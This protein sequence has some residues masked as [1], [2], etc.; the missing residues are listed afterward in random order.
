MA[1]EEDVHYVLEV[2]VQQVTKTS[3]H[4]PGTLGSKEVVERTVTELA[5]HVISE[6][7]MDALLK[8]GVKVIELVGE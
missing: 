8:K 2:K 4:V 3:S 1:S 6:K 7:S 5:H